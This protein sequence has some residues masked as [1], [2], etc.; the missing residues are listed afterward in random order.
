MGRVQHSCNK[1]ISQISSR[2]LQQDH[3]L[4]YRSPQYHSSKFSVN[5]SNLSLDS[6]ISSC[7]Q[8]LG[9]SCRTSCSDTRNAN[10]PVVGCRSS[11]S[12]EIPSVELHNP[13]SSAEGQYE[14]PGGSK[15]IS[16]REIKTQ[17]ESNFR[18]SIPME[19]STLGSREIKL[20]IAVVAAVVRKH[21]QSSSNSNMSRSDLAMFAAIPPRVRW[22]NMEL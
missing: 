6:C 11:S 20:I 15:E 16:H 7:N 9:D 2:F 5:R 21:Q 18:G 12:H 8:Y 10:C 19:A 14:L 13:I 3:H 1:E 17:R 22:G 4:C